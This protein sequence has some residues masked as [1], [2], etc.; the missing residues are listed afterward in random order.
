MN[1]R[2]CK[3]LIR[4]GMFLGL[5]LSL[6]ASAA[7]VDPAATDR[8]F[9]GL[10]SMTA[11]KPA[12]GWWDGMPRLRRPPRNEAELQRWLVQ[13]RAQGADFDAYRYQ[14]TLLHHALRAGFEQTALWLLEQGANPRLDLQD[15]DKT[16][17]LDLA[18]RYQRKQV[19][20]ALARP[21][22]Q[23]VKPPQ[24]IVSADSTTPLRKLL[25]TT[26]Q[27]LAYRKLIE[28]I[29]RE[30]FSTDQSIEQFEPSHL[31]KR[32]APVRQLL[33]GLDQARLRRALNDPAS[34]RHWMAWSSILTP[35]VFAEQLARVEAQ[36]LKVHAKITLAAMT[37]HVSPGNPAQ[38]VASA[39]WRL[40]LGRLPKLNALP[41]GNGQL[42]PLFVYTEPALWPLLLERGY[43]PQAAKLEL[44]GLK[45]A[46][47]DTAPVA[48][49]IRSIP[50]W[51]GEWVEA[52]LAPYQRQCVFLCAGETEALPETLV[53]AIK[54]ALA[55]GARRPQIEMRGDIVF[56]SDPELIKELKELGIL[57]SPS[58]PPDRFQAMPVECSLKVEGNL[59]QRLVEKAPATG[60][61]SVNLGDI[62]LLDLPDGQGCGVLQSGNEFADD[63]FEEQPYGFDGP[64]PSPN[65][66]CPDPVA[67]TTLLVKG[68]S[69][70]VESKALIDLNAVG[71]QQRFIDKQTG[72]VFWFARRS[73]GKCWP[74]EES[75]LGWVK[76]AN[77]WVFQPLPRNE[78]PQDFWRYV[79]SLQKD[80]PLMQVLRH[81][82]KPESIWE[83]PVVERVE[84]V[85]DQALD[86]DH[87]VLTT[88]V[89]AGD[90]GTVRKLMAQGVPVWWQ[91]PML[92]TLL[93][94]PDPPAKKRQL[95]RGWLDEVVLK[96]SQT[97]Y[98]SDLLPLLDWFD[99][100][101][102]QKLLARKPVDLGDAA[103]ERGKR[104]LACLFDHS[105]GRICPNSLPANTIRLIRR[106]E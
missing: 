11:A 16:K 87:Q 35:D 75:L 17:V 103:R 99:A 23:L 32:I 31:A 62:T 24:P 48:T 66:S 106:S 33:A 61:R 93:E 38:S 60:D 39:N 46:Q 92:K 57:H 84:S 89:L 70:Y 30:F 50:E 59:R 4:C 43:Q 9:A 71:L 58:V 34:L 6:T 10:L 80:H 86:G 52:M 53:P 83:K 96:Q 81:G 72:Q 101:D 26:D 54:T 82:Q 49:L 102:W 25:A 8:A 78:V 65:P 69:G 104:A 3:V 77:G 18:E 13:Q 40:L 21:P 2:I 98:P 19:L 90:W 41:T 22:Y 36:T 29:H 94:A 73:L 47:F 5:G 88:A 42:P 7:T 91:A 44:A 68:Q 1:V 63:F 27:D 14:G 79:A 64:E 85:L 20:A 76:T 56:R 67:A 95:L 74:D 15:W 100:A 12:D 45:L 37:Q 55:E 97:L 51:R 105:V 28:A